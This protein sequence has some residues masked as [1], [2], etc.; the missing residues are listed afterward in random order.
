M[1]WR[2]QTGKG[3]SD[4]GSRWEAQKKY[5]EILLIYS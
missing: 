4:E 2:W 5:E 1:G 3:A